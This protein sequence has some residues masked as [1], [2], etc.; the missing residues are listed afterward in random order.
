M[1][2]RA[3]D[4]KSTLLLHGAIS[5]E[6]IA[7][8]TM[9][10]VFWL[11]I[12]L[13]YPSRAFDMAHCSRCLIP[14]GK[15]DGLYLIEVDRI[16][17][18]GGYWIFSGPPIN[19]ESRWKGWDRT[20]KDLKAEQNEIES[21]ARSLCWKKLV[22]KDDIAIWQKPTNAIHCKLNR[23][24]FKKPQLCHS[25]N[26]DKACFAKLKDCAQSDSDLIVERNLKTLKK[27]AMAK[28]TTKLNTGQDAVRE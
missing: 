14:W 6:N 28:I 1:L 7:F 5:T 12:R 3:I 4:S 11:S 20:P 21:V 10:M 22:K 8:C 19:W 26:P 16:L 13:P 27:V 23:K 9:L 15:N 17:R 24:V 25:P 2:K 18:P